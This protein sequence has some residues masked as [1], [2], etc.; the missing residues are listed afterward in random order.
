M[1][2]GDARRRAPTRAVSELR[3]RVCS[4]TW[5]LAVTDWKLRFYG[6]VLGYVWTLARPFAFFG[7]IYVVFTEI[8]DV[9]DDVKNYGVYILF[10]LVLFNFFAEV[11]RR[12]RA[13]RS[14]RARTCCARCA[15]RAS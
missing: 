15:S 11:D 2:R 7:V 12:L 14:S 3:R 13:L 1:T 5:T 9:G 6:S 10:A 8:A 4:L